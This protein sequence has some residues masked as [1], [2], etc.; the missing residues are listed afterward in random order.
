M[1]WVVQVLAVFAVG[2]LVSTAIFLL[3]AARQGPSPWAG[4]APGYGTFINF[5]DSGWYERI[6]REGYPTGLPQDALG[7]V[8]HN[9]WAFY[10]LYP[11]LVRG[12]AAA[13]GLEWGVLA[14][15]VSV[16]SAAAASLVI[17][18]LFRLRAEHRT[19]LAGVA[20][21]SLA[22]VAAILQVPY[23]ESL[24]LLLLASALY[25]VAS[26]RYVAA[27]P[28]AVLLGLARPAGVPFAIAVGLL[29]LQ[30]LWIAR[31]G[32]DPEV[33]DEAAARTLP[34]FL[35]GVVSSAAAVAWPLIAWVVTGRPTAYVDTETAWRGEALVPFL[36]WF[37]APAAVVGPAAGALVV[38]GLVVGVVGL[39]LAPSVR[40]IGRVPGAWCAAYL[41]YLAAF[42]DPQ[43]S[44]WRILLPLFP[45]ALAVATPR[46]GRP[47]WVLLPVCVVLQFLWVDWLWAWTPTG[48]DGDYPP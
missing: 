43:S 28:V 30:A 47:L 11:G 40:S 18:R 17:Y 25:L 27:M 26:G 36:P 6:F 23:A 37:E 9:Q 4:P 35:L 15:V 13:T 1:P 7:A 10:P 29:F 14:P 2:R 22:P 3:A 21:V 19:A 24:H 5:W 39:S 8:T 41:L 44:T 32:S 42:W 34:L 38:V 20:V 45:L 33:R 48:A 16:A 46:R 12:L 31:R